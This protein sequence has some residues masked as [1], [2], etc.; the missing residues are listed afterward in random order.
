MKKTC[1][2][3]LVALALTVVAEDGVM[4]HPIFVLLQPQASFFWQT[5]PGNELTVPIEFPQGATSATLTVTGLGYSKTYE[6]ITTN[7][8]ALTLPA[9][10]SPQS[11]NVYELTLT[12]DKGESQVA[13]VGVISGHKTGTEGSTRCLL[14][15]GDR[16]WNKVKG[17][18]VLPIAQGLTSFTVNGAETDPGL[19][20][21]QG[22]YALS[23][24]PGA[25]LPVALAVSAE[26]RYEASLLG[27]GLGMLLLFR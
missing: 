22:W 6:N 13:R 7:E 20:G 25:T 1:L 12:F 3:I 16:Q 21:A 2:G 14:P 17:R 18:A 23:V 24:E 15:A 27:G 11:E 9:A 19:D 8:C 5:A 4:S 26:E 10:T